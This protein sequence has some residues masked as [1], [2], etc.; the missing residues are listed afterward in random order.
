MKI[1]LFLISN[2]THSILFPFQFHG[3][4]GEDDDFFGRLKAKDINICRFESGYSQYTML[5]HDNEIPNKDRL[6]FLRNGTLRY[7]T[8]G[9]NSLVY[10]EKEVKLH[11]L[12]THILAI[13]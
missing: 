6:A 3:W 2:G 10:S 8:D 7:N 12:F 4:G 13:T 1:S 9:L 11:N 5:K